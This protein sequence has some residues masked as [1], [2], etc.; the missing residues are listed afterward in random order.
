[1]C[2]NLDFIKQTKSYFAIHPTADILGEAETLLSRTRALLAPAQ[3]VFHI[4]D[5]V[6]PLAALAVKR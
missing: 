4:L 2:K 6:D 1:M 3:P 5:N